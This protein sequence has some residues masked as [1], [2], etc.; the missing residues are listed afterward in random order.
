MTGKP[1]SQGG[2]RGRKEATG[3]GVQ[4]G[5]RQ[6]FQHTEDIQALGLDPGLAGKTVS[7]QGFG[8]VGYHCSHLLQE[9]DDCKIV[10]IGEHDGTS[11]IPTVSTSPKLAKHRKARGTIRGFP[12]SKTLPDP[13]AAL[14][15]EC[16]I[17]IPAALENQITLANV[18]R[19]N[20]KMVAEAANGPVTPGAGKKL[21]RRGIYVIPDI[22]LN[23]G[24]V[25]VSYFEW[26]KNLAHIRY[27]AEWNAGWRKLGERAWSVAWRVTGAKHYHKKIGKY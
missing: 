11:I 14:T 24:G 16:D 7:I 23:A 4:F 10:A 21:L 3:R 9:E 12:G 8:N 19:I 22:F 27:G 17:L 5:I 13:Q 18:D 25:T 15:V 6:A 26:G 1:V 2:I 20:V